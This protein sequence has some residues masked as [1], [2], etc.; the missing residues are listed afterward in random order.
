MVETSAL[1]Q[2]ESISVCTASGGAPIYVVYVGHRELAV[3]RG[4]GREHTRV[5]PKAGRAEEDVGPSGGAVQ[6]G[7]D[8]AGE[9]IKKWW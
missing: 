4:R 9:E 5:R 7:P 1:Y 2:S 6:G 8:T 3:R